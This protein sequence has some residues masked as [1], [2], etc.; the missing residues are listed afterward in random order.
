MTTLEKGVHYNT[1]RLS[2]SFVVFF[3]KQLKFVILVR[4]LLSFN[5]GVDN[6]SILIMIILLFENLDDLDITSKCYGGL[7]VLNPQ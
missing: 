6:A 4:K 3:C 5:T 1:A 7:A 2:L